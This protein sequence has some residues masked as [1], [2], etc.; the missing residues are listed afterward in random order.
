MASSNGQMHG[1]KVEAALGYAARGWAVIPLHCAIFDGDNPVKCSC[2]LG[3]TCKHIGK[4]PLTRNG[5]KDAAS[6][7]GV[8]RNWWARWPDAN[9]GIATGKK[10]GIFVLDVDPRHGGDKTLG[11]RM[12]NPGTELIVQ[13]GSGGT[14]FYYAYDPAH[15]VGS[16]NGVLQGIDVKGDDGYVVAPPSNHESGGSY[17]NMPDGTIQPGTAPAA[18]YAAIDSAAKAGR[19]NGFHLPDVVHEGTRNETA[20]SFAGALRRSGAKPASILAALRAENDAGTFQPRADDHELQAIANQSEKWAAGRSLPRTDSGNAERLARNFGA[21]LRHIAPRKLWLY[22]DGQRWAADHTQHIQRL[23]KRT[24]RHIPD[25]AGEDDD[26]RPSVLRWAAA[27]EARARRESMIALASAEPGIA[28]KMEDFDADVMKFNCLTGTLDLTTGQL[29]EHRRE[30]MITKLAPVEWNPDATCP[31]WDAFLDR[32][33]EGNTDVIAY[34]QRVVGYCL[35]GSVEEEVLFFLYGTGQNGKSKFREAIQWMMGDYSRP[36]DFTSFVVRNGDGP[37]NDI[38]GLVNVRAAMVSEVADNRR[39][40]EALIKE[41]TG[42]DKISARFLNEEFFDYYPRFK[43]I[44]AG[45]HKP[46]VSGTDDGFWRRWQVITLPVKIPD[47]ERDLRLGAKLKVE[48]PGILRWAVE[49]CLEWQKIGLKPPPE[50]VNATKTYRSEQD[51]MA[52]FIEE[53]CV[54]KADAEVSSADLYRAYSEW[55]GT[56]GDRVPSRKKFGTMIAARDGVTAKRTDSGRG[57]LGIK[58]RRPD[59]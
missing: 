24:V 12:D 14:H 6:D 57:F 21:D 32:I 3:A 37:R 11:D 44:F 49:G 7:P 55:V 35:T 59:Y 43:L 13:T 56:S 54:I 26:D 4:H 46:P 18:V 40:D 1:S 9:V 36:C 51:V 52:E 50:I 48:A 16:R 31:T 2:S 45:N 38:A 17:T 42:G 22:F 20:L 41:L 23:A 58:L 27:S 10:S 53:C 34:V 39:L 5:F 28:A 33:F 8:I 19:K 30:D 29:Y 47:D 15:P 25:E